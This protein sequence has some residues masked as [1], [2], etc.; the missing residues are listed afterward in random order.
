MLAAA[1]INVKAVAPQVVTCPFCRTPQGL[2]IFPDPIITGNSRWLHCSSCGF[3]G[4]PI[5]AYGRLRDTDDPVKAANWAIR[6]GVFSGPVSDTSPDAV[7]TYANYYPLRRRKIA[8]YWS[9]L[10][11]AMSE[12]TPQMVR[13]ARSEHLW[14]GWNSQH[15][16]RIRRFLGGGIR[17]DITRIFGHHGVLPK[18]GFGTN[19]V[20]NFQDVPG[21]TCAF[22]F[23][24]E[25]G[26]ART[27]YFRPNMEVRN[28]GGLSMLDALS[29]VEDTVF[30]VNDPKLALHMHSRNFHDWN[31]PLKLVLYNAATQSAWRSVVANRVVFW[32]PQV[33]LITI[34]QARM[35]GNGYITT[36]PDSRRNPDELYRF[37]WD[38]PLPDIV[39]VMER[40][41]K[42][43]REYV[44]DLLLGRGAE[45]DVIRLIKSMRL[46][47]EERE[48]ITELCPQSLRVRLDNM[49]G[50]AQLVDIMTFNGINV[51]NKEEGWFRLHRH[52]E[53]CISDARIVIYRE[54]MDPLSVK[55]FWEGAILFRG[56]EV[57][58]LDD[59]DII[60]RNTEKW[61]TKR[62]LRA[63]LGTP[64]VRPSWRGKLVNMAKF[65][66]RFEIL[67]A[68][69]RV[70]ISENGEI[71]F[72]GFRIVDGAI[73]KNNAFL[74]TEDTPAQKLKPPYRKSRR[75]ETEPSEAWPAYAAI[76][77]AFVANL[78]AQYLE[79]PRTPIAVVGGPGSLG[80][81]VMKTF[82][83]KAGLTTYAL[84]H[85]HAKVLGG[86]RSGLDAYG[87][88]SFVD[89]VREGLLSSYPVSNSDHVFVGVSLLEGAA[90]AVG[91]NWFFINAPKI[92]TTGSRMPLID[93]ILLYLVDLQGR[94][95]ALPEDVNLARSVL[96]DFLVWYEMYLRRPL[97]RVRKEA[98]RMLRFPRNAGTALM[99][100][101][102]QLYRAGEMGIDHVPFIE[103]EGGLK[104]DP[105]I[106]V[107]IDD[108]QGHV[109]LSRSGLLHAVRRAKL[110]MPNLQ[111][112]TEGLISR[113][114]LHRRGADMDGW[115]VPL[116]SWEGSV[117]GGLG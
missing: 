101:T 1:G 80:R 114:L 113:E 92:N 104:L 8:A 28:E 79:E 76:G 44:L 57:R 22:T 43:W 4:D 59:S 66:S 31:A 30:A 86:I 16:E 29:A 82:A 77:A 15:R 19:F 115:V 20:L 26:N 70:G 81:E 25:H 74:I 63:E 85:G 87:Y 62:L 32:S 72:P 95:F 2:S 89:P 14:Y 84:E 112:A 35:V 3:R 93:D 9:Q 106:G 12:I 45:V 47:R 75:A 67:L 100:L 107:V 88:P 61:M 56:S 33:D 117:A 60:A 71:A 50:E 65:F 68:S 18:K 90:L 21:R 41:A 55:A 13:R 39:S 108:E 58:F 99:Q 54:L 24:G 40:N 110:P 36:H 91:G 94:D 52:G 116:I 42:P 109:F 78:I 102:V 64:T 27:R 111:A 37:F 49:F 11:N 7:R 5:E 48:E 98:F 6:D 96:V 53:E 83:D 103:R 46:N 73:D 10:T 105:K 51:A 97:P 17:S 38:R 23:L 69:R 34:D